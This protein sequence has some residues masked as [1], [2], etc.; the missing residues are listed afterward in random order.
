MKIEKLLEQKSGIKLD[1]GC[2]AHKQGPDWVGM[3]LESA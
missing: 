1:I 2:G 3:D